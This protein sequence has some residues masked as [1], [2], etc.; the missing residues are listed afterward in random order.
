MEKLAELVDQ[1]ASAVVTARGT[2]IY[3]HGTVSREI[4][5]LRGSIIQG[6]SG[7]PLLDLDGHVVGVVFASSETDPETGYALTPR[8]VEKAAQAGLAATE[9]VPA[10]RC[11]RG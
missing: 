3:G 4:V 5:S 2:D 9:R 7:G 6:D 11:A 10:G 8:A 1:L